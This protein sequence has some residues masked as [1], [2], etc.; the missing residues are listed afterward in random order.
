VVRLRER[1]SDAPGEIGERRI[2]RKINDGIGAGCIGK[3][4]FIVRTQF[5]LPA[6]REIDALQLG[7]DDDFP[8]LCVGRGNVLPERAVGVI[9]RFAVGD[10]IVAGVK[11]DQVKTRPRLEQRG[12]QAGE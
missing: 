11:D 10:V 7:R 3:Q 6:R 2:R 9:G 12:H 1:K 8:A 4:L 5:R